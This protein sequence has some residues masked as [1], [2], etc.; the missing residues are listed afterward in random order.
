MSSR[1]GWVLSLSLV[2]RIAAA[3][4]PP[5]PHRDRAIRA[6]TL[7]DGAPARRRATRSS[8][9]AATAS[10]ASA[11]QRRRPG[12]RVIDLSRRDR[13]AGPDRRAHA[14]LSAGRGS[15]RGGIRR[16]A[17]KYRSPTAP[18][19]PTVAARRAL[20]QGF[21]TIRDVETEGA[22]YGDVGIK[23]AIDEGHIPGP[24]MFVVD[25]RDL[26]DRRLQPRGLR[27]GGRRA[28]RARRSSTVRSRRGRPRAS[29]SRTAPTGSRST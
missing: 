26:H 17:A 7:I 8:S 27:A 9:S 22:G 2:A 5:R 14:H 15:G 13:A 29:S 20:E 6:G 3:A 24:R 10:R 4:G 11:R 12:R 21:T 18:R 16:A 28:R 19:G 23:Q 25:A 1:A